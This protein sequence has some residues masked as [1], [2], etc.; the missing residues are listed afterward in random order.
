MSEARE[1]AVEVGSP[2]RARALLVAVLLLAGSSLALPNRHG[3]TTFHEANTAGRVYAVQSFVHYGRWDLAPILCRTGPRHSLVD[4]SVRDGL[5]YLQKAPG[6]SWLA[7]PPY[8]ALSAVSGGDKLPFHYSAMVLSLLCVLLPLLIV[9]FALGR[10]LMREMGERPGLVALAALLLASPMAVYSGMFQD[11]PLAIAL[12]VGAWLLVQR[13]SLWGW[14]TAG[15]LAGLAVTVNYAFLVYGLGVFSVELVRRLLEKRSPARFAVAALLGAAAP[16]GALA[17]YDAT[18]FGSPLTTAYAYMVNANQRLAHETTRFSFETL[19]KAFVG[20]KHGMFLHAPWTAAGLLGLLLMLRDPRHRPTAVTGLVSVCLVLGF[21]G[22]WETSNM[23]DMP[24][25]RHALPVYP[26]LAIGLAYAI[27]A[28][29]GW[30]HRLRSALVGALTASVL[31]G[32]VYEVATM[33]TLPYHPW[34]VTSPLWQLDLPL[35]INGAHTP[36]VLFNLFSPEAIPGLDHLGGYWGY[37]AA[38]VALALAAL[39][40]AARPRLRRFSVT[41]LGSFL[42]LGMLLLWAGL[43][44]NPIT[45][46]VRDWAAEVPPEQAR[47]LPREQRNLWKAAHLE[48]RAYRTYLVDLQGS[49]FTPQDVLW[50]DAGYPQTN[51][52]CAPAGLPPDSPPTAR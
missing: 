30:E 8:L 25:A 41:A 49:L 9:S 36:P 11:Y 37:L 29:L 33:W 7:V 13:E 52:W 19:A 10:W 3:I 26:W 27:R 35:L 16:L 6:L 23:D 15:V 47:T 1:D 44:T 22:A 34:S 51:P 24:F 14:A 42:G 38:A 50:K 40:V 32:L 17:A 18:L 45:P 12:L 28:T 43:V 21:F 39:V 4:L 20:A 5:P 31:V 48:A 2:W 46:E